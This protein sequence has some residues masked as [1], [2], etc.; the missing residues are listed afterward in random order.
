VVAVWRG[1]GG[2]GKGSSSSATS[3][4]AKGAGVGGRPTAM[5]GGE[6]AG[7]ELARRRRG[8]R[9]QRRHRRCA[10]VGGFKRTL[11]WRNAQGSLARG[12][13]SAVT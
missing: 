1:R 2:G 10:S 13:V 3:A 11:T 12:V 8:V 4:E 5:R 9:S 6:A 7:S